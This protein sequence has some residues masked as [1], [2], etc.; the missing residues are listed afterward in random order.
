MTYPD[1]SYQAWI[2]DNAKNV[3]S[4]RTVNGVT[5]NFTYDNRNR[6]ITM[7][8]TNLTNVSNFTP[9]WAN[10]GYDPASRLTSAQNGIGAVGTGI[11]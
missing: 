1:T 10:F 7:F 5:Q 6:K 4:R 9:E 8:W 3:I 2:Y 11:I